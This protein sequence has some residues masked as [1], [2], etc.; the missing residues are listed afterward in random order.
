MNRRA[1]ATVQIAHVK[2]D[3][4]GEWK[5]QTLREHLDGVAILAKGFAEAF[6]S[7]DWAE[8]AGYWHDLG[9]YLPEWQKYI[10]KETGYDEG[11]YIETQKGRPNHSTA[12]AVLSFKLFEEAVK[13]REK[14]KTIARIIAYLVS[15]HHAGLPDWYPDY[16]GGD[17]QNRIFKDGVLWTE[18]LNR[19]KTE[20][21][22]KEFIEKNLPVTSPLGI[23]DPMTQKENFHLWIRMLFSC[24]VDADY[25]DTE[26][27]MKPERAELRGKYPTLKELKHRFDSFM[28]NKRR[29]AKDN[30]I[31]WERNAILQSCRE[32]AKIE[33]GIFSLNVPTGG[34]KTLSSMA[35][36]LEHA[37]KHD[38]QRIIMAIPYT[39]IIEQTAKVYKYG[40]D[41]EKEIEKVLKT[42]TW[43][44]GENAVLDHHSNIDPDKESPASI[45][46][47]E[48]WDAPVIVTTNVQLFESLFASRPSN[49][50]KLHN[51]INSVI[52]L[53]EAQMLPPEYLRPILSMLQGLVDHFRVTVVLC[54]ATQPTLEGKIGSQGTAFQGLKSVRPIID[55]PEVLSKSFKRV[56]IEPPT[57]LNSRSSWDDV[58][59]ELNHY[60]QVICIVNKRNDCRDLHALMPEGTIHLSALMCGEERSEIISNIKT[61]LRE[62]KP[63]KVISTQLVEAGVDI[64]FPI[65]YRALAGMDSIAQAAGRCNREGKLNAMGELGK[66]V[67]FN[68]PKSAPVGLLR[69]GEDASKSLLRQRSK[70]ELKPELFTEYFNAFYAAV[71]DFDKAKFKTCLVDESEEFKFQFRTFAHE[72]RLID[73][74]A[75]KGIIIWYEG[76]NHSSLKLIDELKNY[77]PSQSLARKLQRFTVTV[78]IRILQ[79]LVNEGFVSDEESNGYFV[80]TSDGLYKKGL[81][82]MY[83]IET[84]S[85]LNVV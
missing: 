5:T 55:G 33:P 39:S 3:D 48:N 46:S 44:F 37:I 13:N 19:I 4:T 40:T 83:D 85:A 75:Q 25:L 59:N 72:F 30:S 31:N 2:R 18:E 35:F 81:G 79:K 28:D 53:D 62:G 1:S 32:K 15:G 14:A 54:T 78:P 76:K 60:P 12:G 82:L 27:F 61:A 11:A 45:L 80:Q 49:C 21:D 50:R 84:D 42:G 34:G 64:D 17:L 56:T 57:D 22:S 68:P 65:V 24:L 47:T 71:N 73:D 8:V 10:R 29:E 70:I 77:G 67:V 23:P 74:Q 41:D 6:G 16:A 43:L 66:V 7:G 20:P 63:V 36:A 51:I 52:I 58:A 69:K 38:K 26:A 9:K